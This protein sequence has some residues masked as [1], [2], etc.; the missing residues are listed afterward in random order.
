[1]PKK[2]YLFAMLLV[3]NGIIVIHYMEKTKIC[4]IDAILL[5]SNAF[6]YSKKDNG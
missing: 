5:V 4:K 6:L 3:S 1:M 2:D